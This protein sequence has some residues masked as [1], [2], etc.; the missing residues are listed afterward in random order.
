MTWQLVDCKWHGSSWPGESTLTCIPLVNVQRI[1]ESQSQLLTSF[2][3]AKT[4]GMAEQG[5][6]GRRDES[7]KHTWRPGRMLDCATAAVAYSL[8]SK[9]VNLISRITL[10]AWY[11]LVATL[12]LRPVEPDSYKMMKTICRARLDWSVNQS[13]W[14]LQWLVRFAANLITLG[15]GS[16]M[17][18]SLSGA[19]EPC[20]GSDEK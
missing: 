8:R 16:L 17:S 9:L 4:G 15:R 12:S 13:I 18:W 7:N 2:R 6:K 10:T 11:T 20:K 14:W 19:D 5:A 1:Q 3:T